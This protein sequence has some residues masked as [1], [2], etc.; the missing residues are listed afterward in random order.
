M[1]IPTSTVLTNLVWLLI[2][3]VI[4]LFI[5]VQLLLL[6]LLCMRANTVYPSIYI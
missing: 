3:A 6:S 5:L 1:H 4:N 2:F